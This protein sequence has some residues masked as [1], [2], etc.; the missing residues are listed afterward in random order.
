MRTIAHSDK[1]QEPKLHPLLATS[2]TRPYE[3]MSPSIDNS[4]LGPLPQTKTLTH[5]DQNLYGGELSSWGHCPDT[6]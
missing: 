4:P 5:Q 2:T 1:N 3:R 6:N